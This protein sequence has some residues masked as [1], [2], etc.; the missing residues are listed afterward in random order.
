VQSKSNLVFK[1][2]VNDCTSS[3]VKLLVAILTPEPTHPPSSLIHTAHMR[4]NG[5]S[6]S[7]IFL[8]ITFFP[9]L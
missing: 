4:A 7:P 1:T 3:K 2:S 5:V 9:F 6:K 8:G